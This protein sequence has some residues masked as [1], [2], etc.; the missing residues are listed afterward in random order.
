M[1]LQMTEDACTVAGASGI[2]K[3]TE[4]EARSDCAMLRLQ[5]TSIAPGT[6]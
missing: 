6:Y 1:L 5:S 4:D 3:L 2:R